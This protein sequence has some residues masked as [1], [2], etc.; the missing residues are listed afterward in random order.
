MSARASPA[1]GFTLVELI[2]V[3]VAIAIL[4]GFAL[5]RLLPLIGRAQRIAFLQ[6]RQQLQSALLLEA[7]ERITSGEAE[8]IGELVSANPMTLLLKPPDNYAGSFEWPDRENLPRDSW[9]YD[10]HAGHLV[11]R[12]GKYTR[13]DGL[14]GPKDRVEFTTLFIY[15]DRDGDGAFDAVHDHFDGLRLEPVRPYRWPD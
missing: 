7:A 12:V 13:F 9:Y 4:A 15:R 14:D 8:R 3:V 2:V 1:R 5:D 11:Y 6:V 10:E